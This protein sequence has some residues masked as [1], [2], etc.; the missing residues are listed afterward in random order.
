VG[1]SGSGNPALGYAPTYVGAIRE[2]SSINGSISSGP[3][4]QFK[5]RM[6][7][8]ACA[9]ETRNASTVWP[10]KVSSGFVDHGARDHQRHIPA[11]FFKRIS[12]GK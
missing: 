5:P 6:R 11:G 4:E 12:D 2:S 9:I 7:G 10:L 3:S 8:R 1:E